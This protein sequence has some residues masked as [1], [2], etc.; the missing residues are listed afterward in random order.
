MQQ[1]VSVINNT[2]TKAGR[3]QTGQALVKK[4]YKIKFYKV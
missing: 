3:K 2:K 1:I 4:N